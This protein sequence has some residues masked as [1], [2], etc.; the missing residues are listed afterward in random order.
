MSLL[1]PKADP[2]EREMPSVMITTKRSKMQDALINPLQFTSK[3][4]RDTDREAASRCFHAAQEM[5]VVEI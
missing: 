2:V 4:D 3:M 1:N 5:P